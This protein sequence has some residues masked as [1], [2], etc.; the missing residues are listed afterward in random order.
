MQH[1]ARSLA[2][3]EGNVTADPTLDRYLRSRPSDEE[4]A[5]SAVRPYR[6]L[7]PA[8]RLEALA[9]LLRSMD[10]LLRGRH[11]AASPDDVSFWRYWTDPS[12][13]GAR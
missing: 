12:L 5:R 2:Y 4:S 8:S 3:A 7:D 10:V 1:F 11:P 13:G 9:E 6:T